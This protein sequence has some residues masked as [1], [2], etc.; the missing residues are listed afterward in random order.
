MAGGKFH[1]L[2]IDMDGRVAPSGPL[3]LDANEEMSRLY[4]WVFQLNSDGTGAVCMAFQEAGGFRS[5]TE[6]TTREDAVHEGKF[7][8]GPAFAMAVAISKQVGASVGSPRLYYWSETLYLLPVAASRG[9]PS[10]SL[11]STGP[12][13]DVERIAHLLWE[14]DGRPEGRDR[15][16]WFQAKQMIREGAI[17]PE[18]SADPIWSP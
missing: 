9:G 12:E 3:V 7:Q 14:R 11:G 18:G 10:G 8:A 16:H 4:A 13:A 15:A 5:Q 1:P 2:T 17:V 6:W